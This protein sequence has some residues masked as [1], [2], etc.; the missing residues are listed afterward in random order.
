M[1]VALQNTPTQSAV[2]K[3]AQ[4]SQNASK[5][6]AMDI[7]QANTEAGIV[8]ANILTTCL[9]A[10][11]RDKLLYTDKSN[12]TITNDGATIMQQM[13]LHNPAA[14]MMKEL[15][16]AQ[17]Q[18]AGDGTT[19]V[20]V[21]AGAL[22]GKCQEL[23]KNNIHHT[24]IVHGLQKAKDEA[25]K[26]I[27]SISR[28]IDITKSELVHEVVD[29][30]LSSK[31]VSAYSD[32]LSPLAVDAVMKSQKTCPPGHIISLKDI[33]L[34]KKV[35]GGSI[36]DSKLVDGIVF[37]SKSE[38][39]CRFGT[40]K[41]IQDARIAL[42]Q[43][44]FSSPKP[45]TESNVIISEAK[46]MQD[47]ERDEKAYISAIV[48]KLIE[49][50]V[51]VVLIQKSILRDS[52]NKMAQMFLN[53]AGIMY[54]DN[55]DRTQ[56]DQVAR[57]LGKKPIATLDHVKPEALACAGICEKVTYG[58]ETVVEIKEIFKNPL[59]CTQSDYMSGIKPVTI[60]LTASNMVL[61]D[62]IERSFVD[63]ISAVICLL[64]DSNLVVGGGAV[65]MS[66]A[67]KL[68]EVAK[69]PQFSSDQYIFKAFAEALKV[70]PSTLA[71]NVGLNPILA[72]MELEKIHS[73]KGCVYGISS[74]TRAIADMSDEKVLQ[75]SHV[76]KSMIT[77]A[78]EYACS[79]LKIDDIVL[80]R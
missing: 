70:L 14:K 73:E 30:S 16:M 45:Y 50:K 1:A 19:S 65:E 18:Q 62:E 49:A 26:H 21:F 78:T 54:V 72:I 2:S 71:L 6:T 57:K 52:M 79:I 3:N 28:P 23:L 13:K 38:M 69:E 41:K 64:K 53:Q 68:Q 33:K 51:N 7:R 39:G 9:G 25:C 22:L 35:G 42:V 55:I 32:T 20:V 67:L 66:A 40:V 12:A 43:F 15:S 61:L 56:M 77:L 27:D 74:K 75:P 76:T 31:V 17:D 4:T 58:E 5:K 46:E 29:I 24:K 60:I 36:E 8:V 63:A 44:H 47:V 34:V 10:D 80:S 11:G 59:P 48:K 37:E